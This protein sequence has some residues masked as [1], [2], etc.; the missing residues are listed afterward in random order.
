MTSEKRPREDDDT[1][2]AEKQAKTVRHWLTIG[3][4]NEDSDDLEFY[5][6]PKSSKS[7]AAL[8]VQMR[9]IG[10]IYKTN[11]EKARK[12]EFE[13]AAEFVNIVKTGSVSEP[14]NEDENGVFTASATFTSGGVTFDLSELANEK[15]KW[16]C[17]FGPSCGGDTLSNTDDEPED[18]NQ[19]VI[20]EGWS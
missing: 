14:D 11:K 20:L 2:P 19:V 9:K 3:I 17:C 8:L 4:T 13:F 6:G 1:Q 18:Y 5:R 10:E 12:V 16:E 7:A 15:D